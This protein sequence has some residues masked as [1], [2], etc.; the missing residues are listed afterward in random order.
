M[1]AIKTE[2]LHS[3]YFSI[4]GKQES[5]CSKE[6]SLDIKLNSFPLDANFLDIL[7]PI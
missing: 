6:E 7:Y 1:M 5:L 3:G 4:H 2:P